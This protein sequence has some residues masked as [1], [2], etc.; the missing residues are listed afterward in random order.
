MRPLGWW[1][2][3]LGMA[4]A[5][6]VLQ[7]R[8]EV[9]GP[10]VL[11]TPGLVVEG[12]GAVLRGKEGHTLRLLAPGITVRG[13][14]VVGAGP[15]E[16]FFE[17]DAAIY[18]RGC[19]GCLLEEVTVEEAPAAVRVE[20]SPRAVVRG[21]RAKGLG[22]SPGVL[23]YGSPGVRVEGSHLLGY[24]DA[25][26]VEY[27]PDMVIRGNLLEGNGRYG[28]HVMFSWGVRVEENLSRANG[29]GNAVMHGAQNRVRGNRLYGHKS[30]VGYGLLVQ[31]ERGTEVRENLFAENT[32][33]LVLMDAQGVRVWG[34]GFQ[35]NGTALRITRE[36]G[37]N[38]AWVEGNAFQGNLYDLLVDDPGAKAKVV[39]NRYDR[40]SGLPV[41]HLPTGAFALL[42]A[43]QP[44]LSLFALSPGVVL[45]E[46]VEAQV[47]GLR[48]VAL[49][50]PA[51]QPLAKEV[52]TQGGWLVLGL[53]GGVLWWRW[54][55]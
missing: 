24:M 17:P 29:V 8:G 26:Y 37:G 18:L 3:F 30:P 36:R 55:A 47:P 10:L 28:F 42:L 39:G 4:L 50:D 27:S 44:E 31:D 40:A 21:L 45:W 12:E 43:R 2:L 38:S 41:P 34:N 51:A 22:E 53:L 19:E 6:P 9:E 54:R 46:A 23:V 15:G 25:I 33:G 20:D 13:L 7:L 5:A 14:K 16:D 32:L 49:A 52:R 1:P 11:T 48:G 35:E